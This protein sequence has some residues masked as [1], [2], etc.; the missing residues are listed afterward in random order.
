MTLGRELANG[1]RLKGFEKSCPLLVFSQPAEVKAMWCLRA[2]S[3]IFFGETEKWLCT[4]SALR[5]AG[6]YL[7]VQCSW[8][9]IFIL[10]AVL[11][12]SDGQTR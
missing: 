11:I 8:M 5:M 7:T 6:F 2:I 3:L 12:A 10:Y 4:L 1:F 9:F